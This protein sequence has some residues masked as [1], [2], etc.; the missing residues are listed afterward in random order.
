MCILARLVTRKNNNHEIIRFVNDTKNRSGLL[1]ERRPGAEGL[2]FH[3]P[4]PTLPNRLI[5]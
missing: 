4:A 5:Q 1:V 3:L 2:R